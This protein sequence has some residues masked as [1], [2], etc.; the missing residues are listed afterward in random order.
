M[1]E[2][3]EA[4]VEVPG[5]VGVVQVPALQVTSPPLLESQPR[6]GQS[7]PLQQPVGPHADQLE[8][9]EEEEVVVVVQNQSN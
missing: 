3:A 7:Q 6:C 4:V 2:W 8:E 1:V 5:T 9:Q